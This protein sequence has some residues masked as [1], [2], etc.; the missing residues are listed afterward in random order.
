MACEKIWLITED[1]RPLALA[2]AKDGVY[3]EHVTVKQ[4][5]VQKRHAVDLGDQE[6]IEPVAPYHFKGRPILILLMG[7]AIGIVAGGL[8]DIEPVISAIVVATFALSTLAFQGGAASEYKML[9]LTGQQGQTCIVV[10]EEDIDD[11]AR[12]HARAFVTGEAPSPLALTESEKNQVDLQ[13]YGLVTTL[14]ALTLIALGAPLRRIVNGEA[15]VVSSIFTPMVAL[16]ALIM[17]YTGVVKIAMRYVRD[18][19]GTDDESAEREK[20]PPS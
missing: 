1:G 11:L 20:V 12:Q 2:R 18:R 10:A 14:S 4:V 9:R 8:M 7:I 16:I 19:R 3:R 5:F 15:D 17:A 13:R 6:R